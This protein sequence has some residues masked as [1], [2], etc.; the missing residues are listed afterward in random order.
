MGKQSNIKTVNG[1]QYRVVTDRDAQVGDYVF[2]DESPRSYIEEGKPYEVVEVDSF[3]DPQF[4]DEEGDEFDASWSASY[5]LL[6]KIGTVPNEL[7]THVGVSY[8][9]VAREAK[10]G[11]KFVVQNESAMDY[12]AG[13]VYEIVSLGGSGNPHF[14]DDVNEEYYV[15]PG[16]YTV[17]EPVSIDEE[18]AV[19]Q[20]RVAELEAMKKKEV[21]EANR[22][23]IGEYAKVVEAGRE[24][25]TVGQ[26]VKVVI[27][28]ESHMPFRTE[29]LNGEFTGWFREGMIVRATDEEVAE[30][31]RQQAFDQFKPGDK[32]RLVSGGGKF[33]LFGF[34][35]G[36]IYTVV[37]N[38]VTV[39]AGEYRASI[40]D[41]DGLEGYANPDQ[42]EKLTSEEAKWAALG[43]KVGEFKAGDTV[44]FLGH[45]GGIHGL[46]KHVGVITTIE[47]I[48]GSL[49]P[50]WLSKPGF[51]ND[52]NG[53]WTTADQLELIAPV[54]SIVNL[55]VA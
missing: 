38:K 24:I 14:N 28:D 12:T 37:Q 36:G 9:K 51:V 8:R 1:V 20:A 31:K 7:V 44:R 42:L 39:D 23:K 13:K 43:R 16:E 41:Q 32:V 52:G 15:T 27:D 2:Y 22:L 45:P 47:R 49:V 17:L 4:I 19:A 46:N 6:E 34:K 3:G 54:E 10:P 48:S 33:P 35:N 50:Y 30:A 40:Q 29:D 25:A 5:E 18:L 21:A 26:I 55:R 11:D 53:T